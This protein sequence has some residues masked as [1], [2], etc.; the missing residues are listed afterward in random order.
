MAFGK[1]VKLIIE[2]S[3]N[4]LQSDSFDF[5]RKLTSIELRR[6]NKLLLD[7]KKRDFSAIL[8]LIVLVFDSGRRVFHDFEEWKKR[9]T[10]RIMNTVRTSDFAS[11]TNT[12]TAP[13]TTTTVP[14]SSSSSSVA[15]SDGRK[16][17]KVNE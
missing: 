14:T 9:R 13:T 16:R 10:E 3:S 7:S 6:K 1:R 2:K 11:P 12:T 4:L 8:M 15:S 5:T 17:R